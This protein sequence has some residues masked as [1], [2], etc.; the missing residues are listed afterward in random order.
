MPSII[1]FEEP[2]KFIFNVK[3]NKL[4]DEESDDTVIFWDDGAVYEN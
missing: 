1:G 2:R 3:E 4:V